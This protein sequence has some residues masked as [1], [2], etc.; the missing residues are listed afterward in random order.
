MGQRAVLWQKKPQTPPLKYGP[1]VVGG[2]VNSQ[3]I[4]I[5]KGK[6]P[7]FRVCGDTGFLYTAF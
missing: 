1:N 6:L 4:H 2:W 7:G 5:L 3:V